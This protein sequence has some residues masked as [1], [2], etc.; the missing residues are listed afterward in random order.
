MLAGLFIFTLSDCG[1]QEQSA[2][3]ETAQTEVQMEN[4][5]TEMERINALDRG[6]KHDWY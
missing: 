3:L 4:D 5:L 6:E 2:V 1:K